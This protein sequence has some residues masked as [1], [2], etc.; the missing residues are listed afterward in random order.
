MLGWSQ[1]TSGFVGGGKN[2]RQATLLA[3]VTELGETG[4]SL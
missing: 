2:T 3:C 1:L 4:S